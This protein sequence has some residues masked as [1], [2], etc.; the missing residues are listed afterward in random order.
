M[1]YIYLLKIARSAHWE[2]I[3][4]FRFEVIKE[5]TRYA[6]SPYI[7]RNTA[8]NRIVLIGN[9]FDLA[10]GL[11]TSYRQFIDNYWSAWINKLSNSNKLF[12][13]D[14]LCSFIV[15]DKAS[16]RAIKISDFISLGA[17]KVNSY[18]SLV[19]QVKVASRYYS[20]Y[21][22]R[23]N[24]N[25]SSRLFSDINDAS[26]LIK[27]VDIENEYYKML[28]QIVGEAKP[29]KTPKDLNVDLKKLENRLTVY[30][31]KIQSE[32][33]SRDIRNKEISS[34]IFAPFNIN[35]VSISGRETFFQSISNRFDNAL[36]EQNVRLFL[37]EY[38]DSTTEW[39][40]VREYIN[41]GKESGV[42]EHTYHQQQVMKGTKAWVPSYFML[43]EEI[44]FLNFNY[45]NTASLYIPK[46]SRFKVNYIHGKLE[47]PNNPIIFGYG[48]EMDEDYKKI[49][50]LNDND[51]LENI[52][53]ICYLKTDNYRKLL[54]FIDSAPY[55]VIIMGHSCGNSDRTLLNTLFEHKNCFSIK[56]YYHKHDGGDNY[57]DIIQNISRDFNDM[58]LMRDRVVNKGYCEPLPQNICI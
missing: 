7:I 21:G 28:K 53:S 35:D 45:T 2:D 39:Y 3:I 58:T 38:D 55:Q 24:Y 57:I 41:R 48:D 54:T 50:N 42:E 23:L 25:C 14:E 27:W 31:S 16:L 34:K 30:L 13:E 12:E 32:K 43:P 46:G 29:Y 18:S 52:K 44:L 9:G 47:S 36:D 40:D 17:T 19:E 37:S 11:P 20:N 49:E 15:E 1:D 33:I 22:A 51:Y 56:P 4:N 10:H 26:C 8:M 5:F 6:R